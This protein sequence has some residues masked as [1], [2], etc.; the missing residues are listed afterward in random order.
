MGIENTKCMCRGSYSELPLTAT[1][2]LYIGFNSPILAHE[3]HIVLLLHL[4]TTI[5]VLMTR[6]NTP[7]QVLYQIFIQIYV[8]TSNLRWYVS[9]VQEFLKHSYIIFMFNL[10]VYR[11]LKLLFQG[12]MQ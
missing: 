11:N 10:Y 9:L 7:C 2:S 1:F 6:K 4:R 8:C 5:I 12:V 3:P